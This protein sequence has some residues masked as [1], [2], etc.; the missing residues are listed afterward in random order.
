M[1]RQK[2]RRLAGG[3]DEMHT[4]HHKYNWK[5]YKKWA[6]P[7]QL[8]KQDNNVTKPR[9]GHQLDD[10]I[11]HGFRKLN[12]TGYCKQ[13][14]STES[15]NNKTQ[16]LVVAVRHRFLSRFQR[17]PRPLCAKFHHYT[18]FFQVWIHAG[19]TRGRKQVL[20]R[21]KLRQGLNIINYLL[22]SNSFNRAYIALYA[23]R[24]NFGGLACHRSLESNNV[25]HYLLLHL[26]HVGYDE[27]GNEDVY[28]EHHARA[29]QENLEHH[30]H[31]KGLEPRLL[32]LL[33]LAKGKQVHVKQHSQQRQGDAY[34]D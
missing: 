22:R 20:R 16:L 8:H 34:T 26:L 31:H 28:K 1:E 2:R 3:G 29:D 27:S 14:H 18:T 17:P 5:S 21:V 15:L 13:Q 7:P 19:Q 25:I 9:C 11:L 23:R 33:R 10:N 12:D 6:C 24:R 32:P 30:P 4:K